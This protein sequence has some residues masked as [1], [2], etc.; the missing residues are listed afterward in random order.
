MEIK[1]IYLYNYRYSVSLL[2]FCV[3]L[4]HLFLTLEFSLYKYI[5]YRA[6]EIKLYASMN[7]VPIL[8]MI[9]SRQMAIL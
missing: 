4:K 9:C 8:G 3:M 6:Y 2:K 7:Y 1:T 5:S